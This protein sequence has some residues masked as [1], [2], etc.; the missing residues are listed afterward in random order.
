MRLQERCSR[1]RVERVGSESDWYARYQGCIMSSSP[2]DISALYLA[3]VVTVEAASVWRLAHEVAAELGTLHVITAWNPGDERPSRTENEH[4]N[5]ALHAD[6][7]LLG[8]TPMRAL[9][10]DPSSSHAE[11]SFAVIGFNDRDARKLGAK[12]GQVAVFRITSATQ[13]VLAC[14]A[15]WEVERGV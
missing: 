7:T 5:D 1:S 4:A 3:T 13:T 15:P 11:E 8:Y 14:L 12:Y 2:P 6:L 9:G 10:S